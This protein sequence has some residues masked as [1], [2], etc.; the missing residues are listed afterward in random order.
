MVLSCTYVQIEQ[1]IKL[2]ILNCK[3]KEKDKKQKT[4]TKETRNADVHS[5]RRLTPKSQL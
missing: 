2:M 1:N 4:T 3:K 5:G